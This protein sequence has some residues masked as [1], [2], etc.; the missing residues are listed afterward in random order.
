MS[1]IVIKNGTTYTLSNSLVT[2]LATL[3]M[4]NFHFC[5]ICLYLH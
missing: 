4:N 3:V 5:I 2:E 1:N